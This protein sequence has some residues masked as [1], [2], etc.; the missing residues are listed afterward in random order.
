M[1]RTLRLA[2]AGMLLAPAMA[3]AAGTYNWTGLYLGVQG[4]ANNVTLDNFDS[5][6]GFTAAAFGGYDFTLA[7]HFVLGGDL[8]YEWNQQKSHDFNFGGTADIGTNVYGVD[9]LFGFPLGTGGGFMPYVKAG[10]GW[11]NG[12]GDL[13]G[14]A[15]SARYGAG[16]E[17]RMNDMFGL[18][19]QYMYQNF[20]SDNSNLTNNNWTVGANWHFN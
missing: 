8:F 20:G 10:Y 15:N 3:F 14:H 5:A 11:A 16:V 6:T 17:W 4:G 19:F 7:Q 12:T 2:I 9:V 18:S 13:S 1:K